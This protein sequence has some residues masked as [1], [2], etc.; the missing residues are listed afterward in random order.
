MK[1]DVGNQVENIRDR[2]RFIAII[3]CSYFNVK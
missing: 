2:L 3:F 1:F